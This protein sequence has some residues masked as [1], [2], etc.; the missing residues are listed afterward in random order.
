MLNLE[1]YHEKIFVEF[2]RNEL[3]SI[4]YVNFN[5]VCFGCVLYEMALG[6]KRNDRVCLYLRISFLGKELTSVKDLDLYPATSSEAVKKVR[7]L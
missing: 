2:A 1:R 5:V 6:T 4:Q 7:G 3:D